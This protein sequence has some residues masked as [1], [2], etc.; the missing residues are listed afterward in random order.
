MR[1]MVVR[2][3]KELPRLEERR[4]PE[5]GPGEV[6]IK[7][8]ACGVCYSDHFVVDGLWPGLEL[9]RVPGHEVVGTVD[10]LGEGVSGFA[11]GDAVGVGWHG[12]H[13]GTCPACVRGRFVH[14]QTG[15]ITGITRDG[16]YADYTIA[17]VTALA[18]VPAGMDPVA[19][20]PL[21]CAG[22][23]TFNAL[24]NADAR[25]GDLV[26]VQGLGGLGHLGV[27]FAKAMGFHT[28]AISRGGDKADFARQL[29]AHDY[30]DSG[31][32]DVAQRLT[33]MGGARVILTTAP[34]AQ[35]ISSVVGGLGIDGTLLVVGAP[36]EPLQIGAV[37]LISRSAGVRGWSSGDGSDSSDALAFA[38]RA[39][40]RSMNEVFAL[41]DAGKAYER[42][43]SGKARFRV[44][45]DTEA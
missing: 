33:D 38:H 28:V 43:V 44:V 41:G 20:A 5:P 29:G 19:A 32:A 42:M 8:R 21:L 40:V 30:I 18:R 14:C 24:R 35:A 11:V 31:D 45:L 12:G 23:T 15:A 4:T 22:V 7:V 27:Q 6:R 3:P 36:F 17:P 34:D 9:P 1:A 16:G 39:G 37:D 26:A 10:A 25:P 2:A 13:D